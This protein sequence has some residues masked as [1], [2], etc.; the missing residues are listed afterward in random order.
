METVTKRKKEEITLSGGENIEQPVVAPETATP[1]MDSGMAGELERVRDL[2][3]GRQVKAQDSRLSSL[4][5][6]V[7]AV[8][9]E[10]TTLLEE[11]ITSLNHSLT[12]QLEALRRELS[13]RLD[14]QAAK[15]QTENQTTVNTLT[16]RLDFQDKDHAEKL[17]TAQKGLSERIDALSTES[18]SQLR[19]IQEELSSRTE[20]AQSEFSERINTLRQETRSSDAKLGDDL[21]VL[22]NMLGSQ[23]VSR[24]EMTQILV[25]MAQ[26][27]Q[28][29]DKIV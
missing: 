1:S 27:L 11:K 29:E 6:Q 19:K 18:N 5:N 16:D 7:Q 12:S 4:E 24:R 15:Q 20:S 10:L 21:A 8:Q 3:F 2:L 28:A 9:R 22:G 14:E 13:S 23:K 25:E 26:R 17:R